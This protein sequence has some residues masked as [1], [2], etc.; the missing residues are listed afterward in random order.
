MLEW[1]DNAAGQATAG[2]FRSLEDIRK[3]F[4]TTLTAAEQRT[5]RQYLDRAFV[6][7]SSFTTGEPRPFL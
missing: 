3:R 5:L 1:F 4:I 7:S 2:S 6:P